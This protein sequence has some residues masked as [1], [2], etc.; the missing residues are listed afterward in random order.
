M[1][2]KYDASDTDSDCEC[3][4]RTDNERSGMWQS[5]LCNSDYQAV[6]RLNIGQNDFQVS[7]IINMLIFIS[8]YYQP[9]LTKHL[10]H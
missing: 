4:W 1:A 5:M 2:E 8:R 10:Q 7:S 3:L 9:K 6:Q